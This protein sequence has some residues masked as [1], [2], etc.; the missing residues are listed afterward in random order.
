MRKYFNIFL[1]AV[2]IRNGLPSIQ[3]WIS[4]LIDWS[5]PSATNHFA[6]NGNNVAD[7]DMD[8]SPF[9]SSPFRSFSIDTQKELNG[10]LGQCW[11]S[12]LIIAVS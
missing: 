2:V 1:G 9:F 6:A 3:A 12:R 7:I 5:L 11:K 4:A 8:V 10:A